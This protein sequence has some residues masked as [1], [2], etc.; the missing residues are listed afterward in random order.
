[1]AAAVSALAAGTAAE[2]RAA[3]PEDV[4]VSD[5]AWHLLEAS[6]IAEASN[7]VEAHAPEVARGALEFAKRLAAKPAI[8]KGVADE[9]GL[10][11]QAAVEEAS[12]Q[13]MIDKLTLENDAL[14]AQSAVA[15]AR[16]A[17]QLATQNEALAGS[18]DEITPP[19]SLTDDLV[20]APSEI[21]GSL[22]ASE[23][24]GSLHAEEADVEEDLTADDA[25]IAAALDAQERVRADCVL[26]QELAD[27]ELA[28]QL[29]DDDDVEDVPESTATKDVPEDG[30]KEA[31]DSESFIEIALAL[32]SLIVIVAVTR[33]ISP[34]LAR[35][36]A[37]L[38]AATLAGLAAF[39]KPCGPR[40]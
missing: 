4:I 35:R 17:N 7:L 1:M 14:A 22:H 28:R 5:G 39:F 24:D 8:Q 36:A 32:A 19:A 6:D 29:S 23:I 9:L 3:A 37:A 38:S 33:K 30:E 31:C 13:D 16:L 20:E 12:L 26:A 10:H 2:C 40:C 34:H 27:A 18:Y 15:Q 25:A 11:T 21:D